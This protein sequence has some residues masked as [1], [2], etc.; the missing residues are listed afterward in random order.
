[1]EAGEV[2]SKETP[3]LQIKTSRQQVLAL[4]NIYLSG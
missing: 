4:I 1:M 3:A 2:D